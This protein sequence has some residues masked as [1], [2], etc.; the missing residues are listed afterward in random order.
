MKFVAYLYFQRRRWTQLKLQPYTTYIVRHMCP[1]RLCT[2]IHCIIGKVS[3]FFQALEKRPR[4][5]AYS[6]CAYILKTIISPEHYVNEYEETRMQKQEKSKRNPYTPGIRSHNPRCQSCT[7]TTI[8]TQT[9]VEKKHHK[10][11]LS[12]NII[13]G[14]S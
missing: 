10:L 4:G 9:F 1:S 2:H 6:T 3:S 13:K 11:S 5:S 12:A 14:S 7:F 8:T